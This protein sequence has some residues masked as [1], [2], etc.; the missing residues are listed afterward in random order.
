MKLRL[1]LA[2][3]CLAAAPPAAAASAPSS[4]ARV[5]RTHGYT[6]NSTAVRW[7]PGP[8]LNVLVATRAASADGY[9]QRAFLFLGTRFLGYV[10]A[11]GSAG[12]RV[13]WQTPTTTALRYAIYRQSD[14]LCC[15]HG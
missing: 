14:P 4:A 12:I 15:P 5:V 10:L 6:P 1:L 13:A 9:A 8:S 3:L 11:R 2:A 7:L